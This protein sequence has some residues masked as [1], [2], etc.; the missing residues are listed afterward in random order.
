MTWSIDAPPAVRRE[1][2]EDG[3]E[4]EVRFAAAR[5]PAV[6]DRPVGAEEH[7]E[8]LGDAGRLRAARARH[9]VEERQRDGDAARAAQQGPPTEHLHGVTSSIMNA[10]TWVM[11]TSRSTIFW[12]LVWNAPASCVRVGASSD[13]S[14]RPKPKR[15]SSRTA[16][17]ETC[18]LAASFCASW[19]TPT[20][21]P[22]TSVPFSMPEA[23]MGRPLSVS[24]Q[25]PI[26]SKFSK[27]RPMGS[28]NVW[29]AAHDATELCCAKRVRAVVPGVIT[30]GVMFTLAG[31]GGMLP[32]S[33][34]SKTNL[35]R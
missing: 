7:D 25:R 35:P 23:S 15:N 32:H 6:H 22:S 17:A 4:R 28:M 27:A 8:A 34:S 30:G 13:V 29:Q 33:R 20:K 12:R 11:A 19:A 9:G 14:K 2:R 21:G 26:P 10:G 31:G 16:Q 5:R 24:R 1:R 3:R 18:E